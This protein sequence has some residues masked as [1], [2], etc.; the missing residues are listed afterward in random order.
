MLDLR[1]TRTCR[2]IRQ[3]SKMYCMSC[4]GFLAARFFD[5]F[6]I[7]CIFYYKLSSQRLGSIIKY[8]FH[9]GTP[10]TM[11][12]RVICSQT[13]S[14]KNLN[15]EQN[16]KPGKGICSY[17]YWIISCVS[18]ALL[19][20]LL[21]DTLKWVSRWNSAVDNMIWPQCMTGRG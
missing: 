15:G 10:A 12:Y 18:L 11:V 5:T 6:C 20:F 9:R 2:Y 16:L 13:I 1:K 17:L 8:L 14:M 7:Q 3:L 19:C 4:T 21:R